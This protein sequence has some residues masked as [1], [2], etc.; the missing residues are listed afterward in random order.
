MLET[1]KNTSILLY[2]S[3]AALSLFHFPESLNAGLIT[4]VFNTSDGWEIMSPGEDDLT[5]KSGFVDPGYGG[6]RYDAEFLLYNF[7]EENGVLSI[8]LQTGFN[9][10]RGRFRKGDIYSG[11][12]ALSFDGNTNEYE[13]A[14]DFGLITKDKDGDEVEAD[15][16]GDGRDTA[17]LYSVSKWNNDISLIQSAPFAMD[18]GVLI[19]GAG[20]LGA[21]GAQKVDSLRSFYRIVNID[22]NDVLTGPNSW[23]EGFVLDVHWTMSCGN[24]EIFGSVSIVPTPEPTTLLLV[25][26]GG[27]IL[28][29][30]RRRQVN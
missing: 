25:G 9:I 5:T 15:S 17:G 27:L 28:A 23:E 7:D 18:T 3:L 26:A 30:I 11:D 12:L 13:Y 16:D 8:G 10:K 24:D 29:L 1:M 2:L 4:S 14:F 22:L 20:T 19:T 21:V 6:Q